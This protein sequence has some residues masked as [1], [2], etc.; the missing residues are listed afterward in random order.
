MITKNR[1]NTIYI[2]P[3][4]NEY[5]L[6]FYLRTEMASW[7]LAAHSA[8]YTAAYLLPEDARRACR[9]A[10]ETVTPTLMLRDLHKVRSHLM[11]NS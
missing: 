1:I 4:R 5:L 2:Y 3:V 7:V 10:V 11:C 9:I 8:I 6:K